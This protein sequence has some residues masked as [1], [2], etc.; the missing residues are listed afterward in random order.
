MTSAIPPVWLA[1]IVV[2]AL[3][4]IIA[5]LPDFEDFDD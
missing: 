1:F 5:L 2:A 4:S 3:L